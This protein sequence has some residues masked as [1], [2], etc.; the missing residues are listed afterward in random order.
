MELRVRLPNG[1]L[2]IP[3]SDAV[4]LKKSLDAL[5]VNAV[6]KLV[7]E[8]FGA[9]VQRS[10]QALKPGLEGIYEVGPNGLPNLLRLPSSQVE[11]IGLAL[12][13]A[14][15]RRLSGAEL[16][17]ISKVSSASGSYINHPQYK[18]N[19]DRDSDGLVGLTHTGSRWVTEAVL[20]KLKRVA[21]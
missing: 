1:E 20:P 10:P 2:V 13:A 11:A 3:F 6:T 14:S 16:N 12:Y 17:I 9:L 4:D 8:R 15:P 5:D 18:K 21:T 19:F 7:E